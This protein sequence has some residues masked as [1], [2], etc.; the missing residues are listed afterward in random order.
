MR[1][2]FAAAI[3]AALLFAFATPSS[4]PAQAAPPPN[5]DLP[6]LVEKVLPGVV[7]ISSTTVLTYQVFGMDDFLNFW[8]V[9][10][11]HKEKQSS[12]GTGF[13]IDKDGYVLTNNH[14]V[15]RATE[16]VVTLLDKKE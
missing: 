5:P 8:G 14:V 2:P 1:T 13:I 11:E 3:A 15:D 12:L 10:K 9:P 16:V 6:D 7:N 4:T